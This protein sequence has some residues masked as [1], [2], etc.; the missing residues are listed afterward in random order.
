MMRLMSAEVGNV[1]FMPHFCIDVIVKTDIKN[2]DNINTH[3]ETKNIIKEGGKATNSA[4][5]LASLG[6]KCSIIAKTNEVGYILL[7]NFRKNLSKFL[8]VSHIKKDGDLAITSAIEI[9]KR[10]IMMS[11]PGSLKNFGI[12]QLT[13]DDFELIKNSSIVAISDW[14]LNEKGTELAINVFKFARE[15]NVKT[16]FDA[17]DPSPKIK[18]GINVREEIKKILNFV[19][20][21]SV[22]EEEFIDYKMEEFNG[23]TKIIYHTSKFSSIIYKGREIAKQ[24]SYVVDV[25]QL[26]GA[27]DV[28]NAGFIYAYL[29]NFDDNEK[30]R[31]ANALAGYY[32]SNCK[33]ANKEDIEKFLKNDNLCRY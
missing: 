14:G 9:S 22:N 19:D 29:K 26:T 20:F 31:F 2:L 16:F 15:N 8:D 11:D 21:F 5:A 33:Y 24:S 17:G 30:L 10:N 3:N 18:K 6:I 4:F 7:K 12:N 28:F 25:K 13:E 27:G 32:I 23:E 1:V